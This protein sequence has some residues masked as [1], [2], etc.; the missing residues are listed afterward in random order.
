M[1]KRSMTLARLF[2]SIAALA[3]FLYPLAGA[4]A[5]RQGGGGGSAGG[6]GNGG[7]GQGGGR[8]GGE[9]STTS[10]SYPA[11][12][13]G[14]ALQSGTIG[15][16]VLDGVFPTSMSY[17]CAIPETIGTTTYPNTSCVDAGGVPLP[18]ASC[19]AKCGTAPVERIYW[20]KN[21][22]NKWQAGYNWSPNDTPKPL[23]P[24][25]YIDWGD[26][27]EGKTWP[28]QVL[29]VETN[30]FSTLPTTNPGGVN[31]RFRFDI[32]HVFGQGI[33]ELWGVHAT[34]A[35]P[36]APYSYVNTLADTAN[37]PYGVNV[38]PTAR[39]NI[40]KLAAGFPTGG[41]PGHGDGVVPTN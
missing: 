25:E 26:N 23:L 15:S 36:P 21:V 19:V 13:Y 24:A 16:A 20:Q 40:A 5:Q 27:L 28:V 33:N 39:L 11:N 14:N 37:W 41:L 29:R 18:Y 2:L 22:S 4:M 38:T 30:T 32:W 7:G 31:P 35:T 3:L 8:P 34:D 9:E 1:K 12:F 17:G 6:G 10:L